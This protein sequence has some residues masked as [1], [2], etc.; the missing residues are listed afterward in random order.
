MPSP[1]TAAPATQP[2]P[3]TSP[4]WTI[5]PLGELR[6]L[7]FL[8]EVSHLLCRLL[9]LV[10]LSLVVDSLEQLRWRL[11]QGSLAGFLDR[12]AW[13]PFEEHDVVAESTD[14]R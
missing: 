8:L 4:R 1:K 9:L 6:L 7:P 2:S 10:V 13:K 12:L 5:D 11:G 14:P 3:T